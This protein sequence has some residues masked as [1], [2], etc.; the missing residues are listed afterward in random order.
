LALSLVVLSALAALA[1]TSP[2]RRSSTMRAVLPEVVVTA[3][4]PRW[5]AD[6]VVV[7][8]PRMF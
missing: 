8:F 4:A 3:E 2:G 7:V 6:T 1:V 5:V